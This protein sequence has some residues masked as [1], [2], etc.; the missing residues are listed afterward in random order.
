MSNNRPTPAE[1]QNEI[2]LRT[3]SMAL[4]D[5]IWASDFRQSGIVIT[6]EERRLVVEMKSEIA[7]LSALR[8]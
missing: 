6:A 7:R 1:I 5:K 4:Q 3:A 8:H 2:D